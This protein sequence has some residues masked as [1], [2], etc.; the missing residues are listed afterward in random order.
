MAKKL[1]IFCAIHNFNWEK[2][3]LIYSLMDL[4]YDIVWFD[5]GEHGYDQYSPEWHIT[6]KK[7]MNAL[8]LHKFQKAHE[9][10]PFDLFF[11][12]LSDP[13]V[14]VDTLEAIKESVERFDVGVA[15]AQ[16]VDEHGVVDRI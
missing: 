12:Y 8:L 14:S 15:G 3:N 7:E 10:K 13:V 4:G 5:W 9:D 1:R 16:E 6:E 11:G 2:F